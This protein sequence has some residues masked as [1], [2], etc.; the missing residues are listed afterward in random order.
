MKYKDY[1]EIL[2]VARDAGTDDIKRAYR[3]LARKYPS[4]TSPRRRTPRS[5]SRR[6]ARPTRRSRTPRSARRTTA[7]AAMRRARRSS[8]RPTGAAFGAGGP[9]GPFG[10]GARSFED[11]DL[12]DLF[13]SF[14]AGRGRRSRHRTRARTATSR[15][16]SSS[17]STRRSTAASSSSSRA[18]CSSATT[19]RCAACRAAS[20]C[21]FPSGVTDG[22]VLRV[23]G[24]GRQGPARR[25]GRRP[26]PRHP[27]RAAPAVPR[28][29]P[30]PHDGPAARAVGSRA[31]HEHRGAD[32]GRPGHAQGAPRHA[33]PARSCACPVA[34]CKRPDGTAGDLYAVI[35]IVVPAHADEREKALYRQLAEASSFAPRASLAQEG[36]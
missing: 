18:R 21:G 19:A 8:R 17:R 9:Q 36:T 33:R 4:R 27:R 16:T 5:A 26:L 3:K 1:Y 22:Q 24:Q 30:R 10:G 23:P 25:A 11:I 32:A 31:R 2:G 12:S 29:R 20:A 34:G 13:A 7:S 15:R 14:G 6:W 28:R 35:E